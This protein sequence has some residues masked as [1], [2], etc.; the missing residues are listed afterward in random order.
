[1]YIMI[2]T[3]PVFSFTVNLQIKCINKNNKIVLKYLKGVLRYLKGISNLKLVYRN[4]SNKI[5]KTLTGYVDSNWT[6]EKTTRS[7]TGFLLKFC[8]P[9]AIS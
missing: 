1:M 2:C 7:T 8:N 9:C 6:G 5:A 4:D 3:R